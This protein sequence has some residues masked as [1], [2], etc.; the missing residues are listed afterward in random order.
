M[1][2]PRIFVRA[3][4]RF[5]GG[6]S[7]FNFLA[8]CRKLRKHRRIIVRSLGD[9]MRDATLRL[10]NAVNRHQSAAEDLRPILLKHARPNND[11]GD[12]GFILQRHEDD[13]G[14]CTRTLTD[15]N[16]AGNALAIF[17]ARQSII[18]CDAA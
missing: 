16:E 5:V 8:R 14:S 9:Y 3:T 6:A 4:T 10:H 15:K 12:A 1:A 2:L 17:H 13:A 11:I 7:R 18:G